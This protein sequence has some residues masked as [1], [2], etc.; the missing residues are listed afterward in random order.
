M[1][2]HALICKFMGI[3]PWEQDLVKWINKRWKL[4]GR[5]ELRLKVKGYFMVIF[6]YMED[7]KS[8]FENG[9]YLLNS[10][11]LFTHVQEECQ[12]PKK[13]QFLASLIWVRL[14]SLL[15]DFWEPNNL[16]CIV[17][18]IRDFVKIFKIMRCQCFS[19]YVR[20]CIYMNISKR[21]LE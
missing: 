1:K 14:L 3:W 17:N 18:E 8:F 10:T 12:N 16:E 13:K 2:D 20:I 4:R 11:E 19:S 6:S 15:E 7:Q 21:I 5:V 9:T